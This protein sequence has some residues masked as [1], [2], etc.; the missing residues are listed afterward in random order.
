MFQSFASCFGRPRRVV[1]I[2]PVTTLQPWQWTTRTFL[3]DERMEKT[4]DVLY[5]FSLDERYA[6]GETLE[7]ILGGLKEA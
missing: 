7:L 5:F 3:S 1:A 6:G 2:G 4:V